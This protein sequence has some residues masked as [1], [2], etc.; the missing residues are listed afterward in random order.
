M[1]INLT[2][3][4]LL[5]EICKISVVGNDAENAEFVEFELS[6]EA[7]IGFATE[8]I[9]LYENIQENEKLIICTH[10][11]KVDPAPSQALGFYLTP[12][13]PMLVVKVNSLNRETKEYK[14]YKEIN[15]RARNVNQYYNVKE[16][17][18]EVA[19]EYDGFICLEPYELSKKNIINIHILDKDKRNVTSNYNT[20]VFEINYDGIKEFATMLF[21]LANNYKEGQEYPLAHISQAQA[22]Y[23][24]GIILVEDSMQAILKCVNLGIAYDYDMRIC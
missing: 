16:P 7:I 23:N 10:Q 17:D 15:I 24:L 18:E 6:Q 13:S 20:V 14:D 4:V 19:L 1:L 9:W 12:N 8:L 2:K 21:I 22:G 11:L 5:K 3:S